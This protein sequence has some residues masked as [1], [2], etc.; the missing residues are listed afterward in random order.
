MAA[1]AGERGE[2]PH[3]ELDVGLHGFLCAQDRS[4]HERWENALGEVLGCEARLDELEERRRQRE[5]G[6]KRGKLASGASGAAP[7]HARI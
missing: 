4:A 1:A 7:R 2:A 6:R 3:L 5:Q